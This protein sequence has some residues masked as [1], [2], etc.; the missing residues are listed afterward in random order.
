MDRSAVGGLA[1][2]GREMSLAHES[3]H[4]RRRAVRDSGSFGI[5]EGVASAGLKVSNPS[6]SADLPV[7]IAASDSTRLEQTL[8]QPAP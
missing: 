8:Q 3:D 7:S 2:A 5:W 1:P 4:Q 6:L